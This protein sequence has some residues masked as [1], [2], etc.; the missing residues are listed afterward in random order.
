MRKIKM[1]GFFLIFFITISISTFAEAREGYGEPIDSFKGEEGVEIISYSENWKG[2]KLVQ[3]YNELLQN[4]HGEELGYLSYLY[5]YP[6]SPEGVAGMYHSSVEYNSLSQTIVYN[7]E[8]YIEIFDGDVYTEIDQ[9]ARKISHEYGHHFTSY[10]LVKGEN[11]FF[12]RWRETGYARIRGI[13]NDERV[14]HFTDTDGLEY[15]HKWDIMEIAA[16]DYVQLFGSS[17]AKKSTSYDDISKRAEKNTSSVEY[18]NNVFNI[19]PQENLDLEIAANVEGLYEYW[20]GLAGFTGYIERLDKDFELE[21]IEK[22]VVIEKDLIDKVG[23]KNITDEEYDKMN[24][25]YAIEW[26][27][28]G[29]ADRKYE[30][31]LVGYPKGDKTFPEPIKTAVTGDKMLAYFGS[32]KLETEDGKV[33]VILN[34]YEGKY[35][36]V[37]F[38]KNPEGFIYSS[39]PLSIDFGGINREFV[40]IFNDLSETHWASRYINDLV[41]KDIILG[42]E[43]GNFRPENNVSRAE[44]LTMVVRIL[45]LDELE[46]AE[47]DHWFVNQGY[48]KKVKELNLIRE[49]DYG[50]DFRFFEMDEPISREEIGY[51]LARVMDMS[52]FPTDIEHKTNYLDGEDIIYK[53]EIN[54]IS[55]Y[56]IINGYPDKSFKPKGNATRA[57]TAKVISKIFGITKGWIVKDKSEL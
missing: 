33:K 17:L 2:E 12:D 8:R 47:D 41:R 36:F 37:L 11:K 48:Y 55:K 57:E 45:E 19:Y 7:K 9:I 4:F 49:E 54:I 15:S 24:K 31:T 13:E 5:L 25:R 34:K 56:G 40:N 29:N 30:Y 44:F 27:D 22:E 39:N 21:L 6:D 26:K 42:Y 14:R 23:L 43:D 18:S 28:I 35:E 20:L 1:L 32:T 16:E 10:Y 3:V 38:I 53:K 46:T 52:V 50:K 51:V